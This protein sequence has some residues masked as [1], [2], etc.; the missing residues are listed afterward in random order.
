MIAMKRFQALWEE[1]RGS[2][3]LFVAGSLV[4]LMGLA[5]MGTDLAWFYLN[6]S[7]VQRAADASAL[8]GVV[9]MPDDF[10]TASATALSIA[11]QNGYEDG[12]DNAIVTPATVPGEQNQIQVTVEDTVPT[13]FLKA[14][15]FDSMDITRSAVA[16]YIPPLKLG[17]PSNQFGN[18]CD[19]AY[20][21]D[22]GFPADCGD[23]FWANIHGK[24]TH[25]S[26]G[27]AY[28][29]HCQGG[30]NDDPNCPANSIARTSGYLY[31]I[32]S[33]GSFTLQFV[34]L[35]F[36]NR[37]GSVLGTSDQH[38]TGDRGC[39]DGSWHGGATTS[40][41]CGPTMIVNLYAPDPTPLELSDNGSPVC[42]ATV[43]PQPQIEEQVG[44]NGV[45]YS[46]QTP[47][48]KPCW[49]QS[50][51][52]IWVVQVL[53]QDPGTSNDR[54]GLNRYSVRSTSGQIYAL[55]DFSIYNNASGSTTSFHLAEVPDYYAGKT[56][57]V[58][59]FDP[60]EFNVDP[61]GPTGQLQIMGADGTV[62]DDGTC[63]VFERPTGDPDGP[64][65][66]INT[67]NTGSDCLE[68]TTEGEYNN[69]WLKFE[70]DL[71]TTYSCTTCW[72]KVNYVYPG[73]ASV[74]DTTTW[75]AYIVGNPIHL[76]G[77]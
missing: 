30:T 36:H 43:P 25:T 53:H 33:S 67:I 52:G 12:T 32:E 64:W 60:G 13:F 71:P 42:T 11:T 58:E 18:A 50:G 29:G 27:D 8:G 21:G 24:F 74:S 16:E 9:W 77:P 23:N 10:G 1:D 63:R 59:M 20:E 54:A 66:L 57:V 5:A 2:A 73:G 49:T 19:P 39:E 31:G 4:L 72:W 3:I 14:L 65:S 34:D 17:S 7:R 41:S 6:T 76:V 15:G 62:F 35:A 56:F 46:W 40:A 38:R 70:I 68:V 47:D 69:Q 51:S 61:D 44:G 75:R 48:G 45:P 55:R 26:F 22:P 28:A 37:S